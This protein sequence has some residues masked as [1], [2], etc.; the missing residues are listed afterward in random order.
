MK[1]LFLLPLLLSQF[2]FSEIYPIDN[3]AV[4]SA[5]GSVGLSND[6][7]YISFMQA[8][9]KESDPVLKIFETSDLSKDPYILGGETLEIINASWVGDS[10][11]VVTFRGKARDEIE[12]FNR[13]IYE[14]RVALFNM[15]TKEFKKLDDRGLGT[16]GASFS[17]GVQSI[18]PNDDNYILISYREFR[19]NSSFKATRYY[20]YNL[21]TG[22][23]SLVLKGREGIYGVSFDDSAN[24]REAYGFDASKGDFIDYYRAPGDSKWR[25]IHRSNENSFDTFSM[26]SY[27]EDGSSIAFVLATNGEDKRALW[28]YDIDKQQFVEKVYADKEADLSGVFY[29]Y[30]YYNHPDEMIGIRT[31]K[32]KPKRIYFSSELANA[33]K[34]TQTQIEQIIPNSYTTYIT[35][36]SKD[37]SHM[38]IFNQGPK[39]PGSYYLLKNGV[40]SFIG[41]QRP[42]FN[43][44]DLADVRYIK[45]KAR[46]GRTIPGYVTMPKGKG[47]YPLIV[48]PHGGPFVSET[49]VWDTWS[50]LLASYGYMVLQPQYRGSTGYGIDHYTSAFIDGGQGG[51]K[52]QDDKDDGVLY[53]IENGLVDKDRVAMFGWS[54][55]GYAALVAA[56]REDQ[57]YQC[58]VSGAPVAKNTLQ[59]NYYR[60]QLRGTGK[61]SQEKYWLESIS[62][63]NEVEK[64][65]VPILLIHGAQDQRVPVEH[66]KEYIAKLDEYNKEYEYIELDGADH[67][68]NTLFYRHKKLFFAEMIDFLKNDC[69][70]NGL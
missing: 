65:N 66:A 7:R 50:Q 22:R 6:G 59:L 27:P 14:Y 19:R 28:T 37:L 31:S 62:P 55:G 9:S 21:K 64:V 2:T 49:V 54:Y 24:P 45:Y 25:E 30:D 47:P 34:T 32:V 3:W 67:F 26:V 40:I 44:E 70:P 38:I 5:M 17:I 58:V 52:M 60:D 4:G 68:S 20:K 33:A 48:M 18:L 1:K 15:E 46:D 23:K 11:V 13:G 43:A 41:S 35:D 8:L 57:L 10:S 56:S 16:S 69:G 39:D 12:G 36:I 51:Y 53:L 63:I 61:L 42:S 29:H